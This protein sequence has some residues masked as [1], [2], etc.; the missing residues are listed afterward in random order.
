M[1]VFPTT[2]QQ[3][4]GALAKHPGAARA[5]ATDLQERRHKQ[6]HTGSLVDLRD[7]DDFDQIEVLPDGGLRLGAGLRL[8]TL[9]EDPVVKAGWPGLAQAAGGLATP[10]IRARATLGGNLLQE[11]RCWYFRNPAFT[12]LKRG[13]SA[14]LAREG[15]HLF[16]SCVDL[17]PCAAP[18]P[19]TL[20]AVLLALDAT[21]ELSDDTERPIAELYGGESNPKRTHNLGPEVLLVALRLP[22]TPAG[23]RSAYGRSI[24]RSR[25]EWPLVEAFV[26]LEVEGDTVTAARIGMG[27]VAN[28]PLRLSEVEEALVGAKLDALDAAFAKVE[29]RAKPL[30]M[31]AYKVPLMSATLADVAAKALAGAG[32]TPPVAAEP[33]EGAPE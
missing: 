8:K 15:D 20:A 6:L 11:V 26:Q 28:R 13:G 16:H 10:Q 18:H 19:S 22:P 31:T 29:A 32:A 7:L 1:I 2:T 23:A 33:A 25:S 27:G 30:P 17:G 21:V 9:A 4:A 3:A 24:H 5:G 12:C 14:C